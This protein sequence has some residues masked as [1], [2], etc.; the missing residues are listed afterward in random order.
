VAAAL[1]RLPGVKKVEVSLETA[2]ARVDF[3][4]AKISAEKLVSTV[5]L[6]GFRAKLL[7][8]TPSS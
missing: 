8:V 3:D 6:L 2:Q 4:D 5:D 7:Q 1:E